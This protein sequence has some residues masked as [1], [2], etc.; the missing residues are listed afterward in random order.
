MKTYNPCGCGACIRFSA[1]Q[2]SKGV[3]ADTDHCQLRPS[4]FQSKEAIV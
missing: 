4:R 3:A 1:C 2:K